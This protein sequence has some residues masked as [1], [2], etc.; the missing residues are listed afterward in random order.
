[1]RDLGKI[2]QMGAKNIWKNIVTH[3]CKRKDSEEIRKEMGGNCG[4]RHSIA[5]QLPRFCQNQ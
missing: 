5:M 2:K 1:M 4:E 3:I